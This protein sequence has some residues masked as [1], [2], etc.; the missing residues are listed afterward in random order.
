[1]LLGNELFLS[2]LEGYCLHRVLFGSI[3]R[4]SCRCSLWIIPLHWAQGTT[5]GGGHGSLHGCQG[6][7]SP[8]ASVMLP[9]QGPYIRPTQ[10]PQMTAKSQKL[11]WENVPSNIFFLI[12]CLDFLSWALSTHFGWGQMKDRS[13]RGCKAWIFNWNLDTILSLALSNSVRL[14]CYDSWSSYGN[15]LQEHLLC[16]RSLIATL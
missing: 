8:P 13:P 7:A 15:G 1:M 12:K 4:P 5:C 10:H 2:D 3:S 11:G 9:C 16:V 6:P 14:W